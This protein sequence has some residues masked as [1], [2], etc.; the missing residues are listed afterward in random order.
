VLKP[1]Q[2]DVAARKDEWPTVWTEISRKVTSSISAYHHSLAHSVTFFSSC[3][4]SFDYLNLKKS[5]EMLV[6]IF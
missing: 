1:T 6:M 2:R 4:I 3:T 5:Q